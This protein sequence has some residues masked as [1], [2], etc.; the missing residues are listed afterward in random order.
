[1]KESEKDK[2]CK[3]KKS[4]KKTEVSKINRKN[5]QMCMQALI[6]CQYLEELPLLLNMNIRTPTG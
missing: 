6:G 3:Q 5:I 1:M 2:M 4:E